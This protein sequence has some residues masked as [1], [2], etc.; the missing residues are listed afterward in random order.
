MSATN[1][2][3]YLDRYGRAFGRPLAAVLRMCGFTS[4]ETYA[5]GCWVVDARGQRWMDFGSYGLHLLGHCH[6]EVMEALR[7]QS[8]CIGLSSRVLGGRESV[9]AAAALT[10]AAP[11]NL[12][13]VVFGNSG[14]EVVDSA[15]KI[16]LISQKNRSKLLAFRRSYH[17]KTFGAL[18]VS[19]TARLPQSC[20]LRAPVTFVDVGDSETVRALLRTHEF[21]AV[22]IE[23]VQ[24]E[25]GIHP[26]PQ[27][28][29]RWLRSECDET[30][31]LM[32]LDEIQTG[33]RRC[34]P[35]WRS[36]LECEPDILLS[37]KVLGGGAVPV[38]ALL[39]TRSRFS[40]LA[41]DPVF[42]ASSYAGGGIAARVASTVLSILQRREFEEHA[43]SLSKEFSQRLGELRARRIVADVRGEGLMAGVEFVSCHAAGLLVLE[44]ARR[45]LL[46]TFC[47]SRPEVVRV[48]PPAVLTH[49][50]LNDGLSRLAAA[51]DSVARQLETR[52]EQ[53]MKQ[54]DPECLS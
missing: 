36:A 32:I 3:A 54:E 41:A 16:A 28:W 1:D 11:P 27:P 8:K 19:D 10:A 51:V 40:G 35:L 44:A 50:E 2:T 49:D 45:K 53:P 34:G 21:A 30:S 14:A 42:H 4:P 20:G 18:S 31:T 46:V 5:S 26:V 38:A 52:D 48:Y 22:I 25:G 12:D 24:G 9:E 47:L 29:L 7:D 37:G 6:E 43:G 33:L 15:L 17:G 39:Y 13:S 23:P